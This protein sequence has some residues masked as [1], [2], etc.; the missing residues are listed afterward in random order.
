MINIH[1]NRCKMAWFHEPY[2][3]FQHP[4]F[5]VPGVLNSL[6]QGVLLIINICKNCAAVVEPAPPT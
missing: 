2:K 3:I 5:Q 6:T 1:I 4:L